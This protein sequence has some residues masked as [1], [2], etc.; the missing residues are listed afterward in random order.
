MNLSLPQKFSQFF[1]SSGYIKKSRYKVPYGG[2]GSGKSQSFGNMV[3]SIMCK[4]KL[5]NK[6]KD[7]LRIFVGREFGSSID[8][9]VSVL[10]EKCAKNLKVWH[11]F[12]FHAK[13]ITHRPT[14]ST[15]SFCGFARNVESFK[16]ADEID[17]LWIEEGDK[18]TKY[19][20]EAVIDPTVREEGSEIWITYNPQYDDDYVHNRFAI[21]S[22]PDAIAFEINWPDNPWFP[23]V[24]NKLKNAS[25]AT[26]PDLADHV[27]GG[28]T[29]KSSHI[30]VFHKKWTVRDFTPDPHTWDGAYNG[31]DWGFSVD[32]TAVVQVW[33][34]DNRVWIHKAAHKVGLELDDTADFFEKHIPGISNEIIRSDCA[35][36][37][38]IS[39]VKKKIHRIKACSKWKGS[40]EDGIAFLRSHK[41]IVIHPSCK[42]VI[43]EA[44]KYKY[45]EDAEGEPTTTIVDADNH[46]WDAIRYAL[47]PHIQ[48]T[49][50]KAYGV[51]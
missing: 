13:K 49:R 30:Q 37:E 42:G 9:S 2:R 10:L 12:S 32:P 18:V 31:A 43:D 26:D 25:Y 11:E 35:R 33:V 40:V 45:K 36:P 34:H 1:D 16:S 46:Y 29:R 15:I 4:P 6:D 19:S 48:K 23:S 3:I 22:D 47:E 21:K 8:D 14:G 41:E 24:L 7:K 17:L 27:W 28:Q 50:K 44:R 51:I 38:T 39:H 5:F 20:F